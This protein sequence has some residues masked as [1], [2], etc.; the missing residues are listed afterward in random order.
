ML[1]CVQVVSLVEHRMATSTARKNL[2][3][4]D[5]S[6]GGRYLRWIEPDPEQFKVW[7]TAWDLLLTDQY[8][9]AEICEELHHRG[10]KFRSGRPFVTI[11]ADG[12]RKAAA[13]GLSR[14]FKNWFYAGWVVSEKA[15]I[16]PKTVRLVNGK[17]W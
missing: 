6:K 8:T 3:Q 4:V 7:R 13:N 12:K 2:D 11:R 10:Y 9:L 15:N 1:N 14:I 5:K 17:R 16:P